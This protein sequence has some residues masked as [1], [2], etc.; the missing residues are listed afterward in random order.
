[1]SHQA[2]ASGMKLITEV[3]PGAPEVIHT[4]LARLTQVVNNLVGN[5]LKFTTEGEVK[6]RLYRVDDGQWGIAVSDKGPGISLENQ[7]MIFE[8]F[9]QVDN[10]ETREHKGVG[11]GLSIAKQMTQH[12]GGEIKLNSALGKGT[13]FTVLFPSS[14]LKEK[15]KG[16]EEV[17]GV[18][19]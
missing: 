19:H 13:T 9:W 11:L 15:V 12:L 8:P 1:M 7:A 17:S 18:R 4:D 10:P 5:A 16:V 14:P 2:R 6:V 3:S